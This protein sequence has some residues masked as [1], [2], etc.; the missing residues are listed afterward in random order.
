MERVLS[1]GVRGAE[2]RRR[3][4]PTTHRGEDASS[5]TSEVDLPPP[6]RKLPGGRALTAGLIMCPLAIT[7]AAQSPQNLVNHVEDLGNHIEQKAAPV[8]DS[9]TVQKGALQFRFTPLVINVD[10]FSKNMHSAET[11]LSFF[12]TEVFHEGPLSQ[13]SAWR[14]RI[15]V[16][17]DFMIRQTVGSDSPR[18]PLHANSIGPR[19]ALQE[20]FSHPLNATAS[21]D[22]HG[23]YTPSGGYKSMWLHSPM[24]FVADFREGAEQRLVGTGGPQGFTAA[25]TQPYYHAM[26]G[27]QKAFPFHLFGKDRSIWVAAGPQVEG[28]RQRAAHLS[29]NSDVG[30]RW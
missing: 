11:R 9:H 8:L 27:V 5:Q 12:R 22:D 29:P 4:M 25:A 28:D 16:E 26:V 7:A 15:G 14:E 17:A 13:H 30:F 24:R 21:E 18:D 19:G 10:P 3:S 6:R 1:F 20:R 2:S 23:N